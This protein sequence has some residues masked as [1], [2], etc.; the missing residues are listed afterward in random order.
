MCNE[1]SILFRFPYQPN[2][3]ISTITIFSLFFIV[4]YGEIIVYYGDLD[5]LGQQNRTVSIKS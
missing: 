2:Q 1:D 4:L 3:I 5:G